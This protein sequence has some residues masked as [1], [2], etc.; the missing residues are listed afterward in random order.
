[1]IV[2]ARCIYITLSVYSLFSLQTHYCQ[3][4][5]S[6]AAGDL[7]DVSF[8]LRHSDNVQLILTVVDVFFRLK[9]V[10]PLQPKHGEK[11]RDKLKNV[12]ENNNYQYL[13]TDKGTELCNTHVQCLPKKRDRLL[14]LKQ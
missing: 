5:P 13:Q 1:M 3:W 7:M 2:V 10:K 6:S 12:V 11:V 4:S 8:Y 14:Y 9:W